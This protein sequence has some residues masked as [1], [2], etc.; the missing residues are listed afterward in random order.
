MNWSHFCDKP[1]P[2]PWDLV[3]RS[4]VEKFRAIG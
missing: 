2:S 4:N 3:C 1:D